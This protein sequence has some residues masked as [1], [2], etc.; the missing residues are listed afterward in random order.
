MSAFSHSKADE[1]KSLG[2]TVPLCQ[3]PC[4][5]GVCSPP[6]VPAPVSMVQ[7]TTGMGAARSSKNVSIASWAC[8]TWPFQEAFQCSIM[9]WWNA[10][11]PAKTLKAQ[12]HVKTGWSQAGVAFWRLPTQSAFVCTHVYEVRWGRGRAGATGLD[13]YRWVTLR[14]NMAIWGLFPLLK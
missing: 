6:Y 11:W 5:A 2:A 14:V 8:F 3:L 1:Q 12:T 7:Q 4:H 13:S 9:T 10:W